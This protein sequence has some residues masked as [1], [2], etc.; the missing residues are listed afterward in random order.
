MSS[1]SFIHL[2]CDCEAD[3][4]YLADAPDDATPNGAIRELRRRFGRGRKVFLTSA[5]YPIGKCSYCGLNIALPPPE[6]MDWLPYVPPARFEGVVAS[7]ESAAMETEIQPRPF[8]YPWRHS[9]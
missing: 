8:A 1:I 6:L 2:H 4:Y 3:L 7:L 5:D 9:V